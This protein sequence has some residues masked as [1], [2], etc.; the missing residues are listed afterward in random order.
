M[1]DLICRRFARMDGPAPFSDSICLTQEQWDALSANAL[2]DMQEARFTAW[3]AR[4]TATEP[5]PEPEVPE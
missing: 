2:T 5:E 4:I 3:L 1:A